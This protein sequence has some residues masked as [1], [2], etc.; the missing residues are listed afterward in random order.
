MEKDKKNSN[1]YFQEITKEIVSIMSKEIDKN[2]ELKSILSKYFK[3]NKD[4]EYTYVLDLALNE[5]LPITTELHSLGM[6][7]MYLEILYQEAFKNLE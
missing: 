6:R 3:E 2:N 4:K 7:K 5:C 1:N